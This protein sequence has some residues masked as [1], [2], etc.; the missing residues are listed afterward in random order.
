M[1][2]NKYSYPC[3]MPWRPIG[4]WDVEALTFSL[5]SRLTDGGKV[6][7]LKGP[8][9]ER[10][11]LASPTWLGFQWAKLVRVWAAKLGVSFCDCGEIKPDSRARLVCVWPPLRAGRLLS[12]ERFMVLFCVRCWLD[13]R[14]IERM[15]GLGQL[16]NPVTSSGIEL[17]TFRLAAQCLNKNLGPLVQ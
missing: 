15:E 5:D 11:W 13:P 14:A 10:V 17:A 16:K 7:S 1:K 3:N 8:I 12:P 4:L 6:V 9:H 2:V